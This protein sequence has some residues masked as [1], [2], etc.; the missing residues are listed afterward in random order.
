MA[1][2]ILRL[3]NLWLPPLLWAA[4]IFQFSSGTIPKASSDVW[5]DFVIKKTG[6]IILFAVLAILFY[7]ALLG[8]G[9]N[10]KRAAYFAVLIA[11]FY[12]AVDEFHQSFTQGREARLRDTFI[13]GLGAGLAIYMIYKLTSKLPGKLRNMFLKIGIK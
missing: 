5:M 12:G 13:D 7:R 2:K 3:L 1:K 4:M 8:E 6:H 10:R 9:V 11:I